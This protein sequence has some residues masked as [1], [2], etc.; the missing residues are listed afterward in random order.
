MWAT[1]G[2]WAMAG[3]TANS[4][5]RKGRIMKRHWRALFT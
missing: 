5:S 3:S 2:S 4:P 1:M